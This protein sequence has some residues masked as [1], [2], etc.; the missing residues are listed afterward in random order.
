SGTSGTP[1]NDNEM[2]LAYQIGAGVAIPLTS[3][4]DLDARYRYFATTDFSTD[5]G[6]LNVDSHNLLLG[7]R[8]KF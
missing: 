4:V 7:L 2:T 5:F 1:V 3:T 8:V 6:N